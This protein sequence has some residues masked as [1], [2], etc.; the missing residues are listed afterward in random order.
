M[1]F[2][3]HSNSI[4]KHLLEFLLSVLSANVGISYYTDLLNV[5]ILDFSGKSH[6][7]GDVPSRRIII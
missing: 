3:V 1:L 7:A 4:S 2:P 6:G 5:N